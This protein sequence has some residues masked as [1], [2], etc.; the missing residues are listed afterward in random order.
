MRFPTPLVV[1]LT[2]LLTTS[3]DF[4]GCNE[5][6]KEYEVVYQEYLDLREERYRE[7]QRELAE[8]EVLNTFEQ[9][10]KRKEIE[11]CLGNPYEYYKRSGLKKMVDFFGG[12]EK[13]KE[14]YGIEAVC[15]TLQGIG[16]TYG[17]KPQDDSADYPPAV[18][19]YVL[20]MTI[21]KNNPKCFSA[22]RV[23]EAERELLRLDSN[24]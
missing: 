1:S 19:K 14:Q 24:P 4:S 18:E 16:N 12:Y 9:S 15:E 22:T 6:R 20:S 2:I 17:S 23:A 11:R 5:T 8:W 3:C 10:K 13:Y 21:I 7:W